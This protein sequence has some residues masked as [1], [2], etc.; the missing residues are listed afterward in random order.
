MLA[1][2]SE[3]RLHS[4]PWACPFPTPKRHPREAELQL[5]NERIK[6]IS[7]K[8]LRASVV[9]ESGKVHC[10]VCYAVIS[11]TFVPLCPF[12]TVLIK[13]LKCQR[14]ELADLRTIENMY[15]PLV[16]IDTDNDIERFGSR[17]FVSCINV[18][19]YVSLMLLEA[20]NP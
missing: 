18:P 3:G 9:T 12:N 15:T 6:L 14:Y 19:Y 7:A 16:S 20:R 11:H 8:V 5:E 4:W 17:A 13:A 1:V 2:D 10:R